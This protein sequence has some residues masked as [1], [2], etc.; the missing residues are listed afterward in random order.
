MAAAPAQHAP[1]SNTHGLRASV[2][3]LYDRRETVRYLVSS[4]LRAGHRDKVLGNLWNLLDPMLFVGV[5][6]VVFGLLFQQRAPGR[7][8]EFILYLSVGVL[9]WRFHGAAIAQGANCVRGNRGLIHEISFPKAVFP[10]AICLARLYDF[11]WGLLIVAVLTLVLG[12][13]VTIY[14]L[15]LPVL[16]FLQLLFTV[17]VA[18][19]VAYLGAFYADTVNIV[20]VAMRLWFY[21]SPI[22]YRV[23]GERSIIPEDHERYQEFLFYYMLNPVACFFESYRDALLWGRMPEPDVL[24]YVASVSVVIAVVG[25]AIFARGEGSF[26]KY[27]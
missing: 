16:L 11:L 15:W 4:Q 19:I 5:Y 2:R 14:W 17:G 21:M 6:F 23:R 12:G 3:R 9:A 8:T 27:V 25:L 7:T 22:F 24:L 13:G 1:R 20:D 10:V 18:F 26:A